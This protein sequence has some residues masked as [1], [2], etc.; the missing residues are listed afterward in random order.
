MASESQVPVETRDSSNTTSPAPTLNEKENQQQQ[1]SSVLEPTPLSNEKEDW[2]RYTLK[3]RPWRACVTEFSDII[4]SRYRGTG[5]SDDPY[6]VQ[7]LGHDPANPKNWSMRRKVV[8]TLVASLMTLCVSLASSAY[9][10]AAREIIGEFQ[11]SNEVFLIG[12]SLF[13]LGFGTGPL[14]WA[15]LSETMGRRKVLIFSFVFYT[16]WTGI[17]IA[18]KNI[19]TLIVFRAFAG[20]IGSAAMVVPGGQVADLFEAKQRGVAMA[21]FS[22][23]PFL[24]PTVG[25]IVGGFLAEAAGWHWLFGLLTI[26]AG[27]LTLLGMLVM[28]ETYAPVMLRER[29]RLLSKVT[30]KFYT[31]KIDQEQHVEIKQ[32]IK[33][34][35]TLPWALLFREP[36]VL[37]LTIYMA[38][39]YG[40]LYLCFAAFPIVFQEGRGWSAGIGGLPF[41]GIMVGMFIGVLTIILDNR[42][43]SRLHDELGGFVPPEVRLP[44]CIIGG[45]FTIIGLAWLAATTSPSIPWIVPILAG[46]PFGT[47]FLLIFMSC[48]N[49]LIDSYVIYGAS[50]MAA[51][52]ILRSLFGA[53]FPLFTTY[54]YENLGSH[55]A[56]AVPGFIALA[57]FPFPIFFYKY[58]ASIRAK[59]KYSLQAAR[60]L[61]S[62]RS[63]L[64]KQKSR[65]E[66]APESEA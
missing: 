12:L 9:T 43:Y 10:G 13:V 19:Q 17:C 37:L 15:P 40:T 14:I 55:W 2:S 54:M 46:V 50:V 52:S 61:E 33:A 18:A 58:G 11:C 31:T 59:C 60:F 30:G 66:A 41:L 22:A 23:A 64:E 63:D 26:F 53:V 6:I 27:T 65:G 24:G 56:S 36:I 28:P 7:W 29:A 34:A 62:L 25:P 38:V 32:Q 44:P 51:N 42:R 5:T 3:K 47:G 4:E 57:C 20:I 39:V 48:T 49:Y 45:V 21:A 16:F 1:S 8:I 35:L